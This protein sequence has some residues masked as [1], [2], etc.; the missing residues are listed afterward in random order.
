MMSKNR[1]IKWTNL[2][3]HSYTSTSQTS[4]SFGS[5]V[6]PSDEWESGTVITTLLAAP[7]VSVLSERNLGFIQDCIAKSEGSTE[8][9]DLGLPTRLLDLAELLDG[10]VKLVI[11]HDI[12]DGLGPNIRYAALSYC[13]GDREAARYQSVTTVNNLKDRKSGFDV[14]YLSPVIQDA[15]QVRM[16]LRTFQPTDR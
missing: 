13:W 6:E 3:R 8:S 12:L 9:V 5:K 15:I 14:K 2:T 4:S 7:T 16:S 11:S 10:R 1:F